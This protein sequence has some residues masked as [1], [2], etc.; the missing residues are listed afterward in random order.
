MSAAGFIHK[1]ASEHRGQGKAEERSRPLHI[2]RGHFNKQGNLLKKPM[3]G[4]HKMSRSFHTS[5]GIIV[6]IEA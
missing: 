6:Y 2:G 1:L 4:G 5:V 3:L